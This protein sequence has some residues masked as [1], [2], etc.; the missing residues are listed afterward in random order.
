MD[1]ARQVML[2]AAEWRAR[3]LLL[4]ELQEAG[5]EVVALPSLRLVVP[6]LATRRVQPSIAVLDVMGDPH[7]SPEGVEQ[8]LELLGNAPV[9]LLV[10][11]Y[12]A[13]TYA[14]F[15]PQVTRWLVRP[16]RVERIVE[17]VRELV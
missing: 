11:T 17:A 14:H 3:T 6:A 12:Q 10:G 1:E 5:Y 16:V 4:A 13:P 2:V 9:V 15:E 8:V 7:A